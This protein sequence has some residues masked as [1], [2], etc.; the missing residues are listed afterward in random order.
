MY[1]YKY[2]VINRGIV[3]IR[4]DNIEFARSGVLELGSKSYIQYNMDL[5]WTGVKR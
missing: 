4:T 2:S 1:K 3:V 5:D